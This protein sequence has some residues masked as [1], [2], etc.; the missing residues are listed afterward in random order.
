MRLM[1]PVIRK[2]PG[3]LREDLNLTGLL[4]LA[5]ASP[6]SS[7]LPP[8]HVPYFPY[9]STKA[10]KSHDQNN[11][12]PV[13]DLQNAV[14]V[15]NDISFRSFT[16]PSSPSSRPS[17]SSPLYYGTLS[18]ISPWA[19]QGCSLW[20][21]LALSALRRGLVASLPRTSSYAR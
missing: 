20:V 15:A 4:W 1:Q 12:S 19:A 3:N 18:A 14:E 9:Q 5:P 7:A 10:A 17:F 11:A 21:A 2:Q 13:S 16:T 6:P 8:S